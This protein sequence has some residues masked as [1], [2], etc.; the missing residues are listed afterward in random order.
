MVIFNDMLTPLNLN[1]NHNTRA[2]INH[3]LDI[4]QKQTRHYGTY[5]I[6]FTASEVWNDISRK[7]NKDPLYCEFPA[8][9]KPY[10]KV[11]SASMKII[12]EI[13][14]LYFVKLQF[15]VVTKII[16]FMF[17]YHIQY[18]FLFHLYVISLYI[19]YYY[20]YCYRYYHCHVQILI[21]FYVFLHLRLMLL[22]LIQE[23]FKRF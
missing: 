1:H 7:S 19:Y 6:V 10:L 11:F 12:I 16:H 20:Y 23:G 21:F 3:L 8:F 17:F 5:S 14:K 22:L 9:R 2:A 13:I 4:P 15:M 18:L